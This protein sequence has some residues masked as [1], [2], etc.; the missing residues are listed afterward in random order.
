MS[1][2]QRVSRREFLRLAGMTG[3]VTLLAAC[4]PAGMQAPAPGPAAAAPP[5]LSLSDP[6]EVGKALEAE[7]AEVSISSWGWSGLA[8]T[9][10]SEERRVW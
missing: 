7:G 3:G 2:P 8:E 6:K 9:H 1:V 5:K 10:R 4:V